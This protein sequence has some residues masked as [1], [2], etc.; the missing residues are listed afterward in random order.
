VGRFHGASQHEAWNPHTLLHVALT[1]YARSRQDDIVARN[2]AAAEA[3][4]VAAANAPEKEE[5]TGGAKNLVGGVL[6]GSVALSV[7]FYW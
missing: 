1:A 2:N 3:A 4:R 5:D 7:P 6:V